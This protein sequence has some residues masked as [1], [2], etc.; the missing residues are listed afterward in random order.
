MC[1]AC[2]VAVALAGCGGDDDGSGDT[3]TDPRPGSAQRDVRAAVDEYVAALAGGDPAAMCAVLTDRAKAAV[4]EFLPSTDTS[5]GCEDVARRLA[6]RSVPLRRVKVDRI[7]VSGQVATARIN[8]RRPAYES[9]VQ[10]TNEDGGWK[11]SY[12]PGVLEKFS[13]PPG[14]PIEK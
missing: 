8:S 3:T 7:S 10:L 6:R 14:V 13:T 4:K 9:E 5:A 12:P 2:L 1:A 11:I